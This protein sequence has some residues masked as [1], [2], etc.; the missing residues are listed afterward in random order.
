MRW[1]SPK[2]SKSKATGRPH[3]RPKTAIGR[4]LKMLQRGPS[5]QTFFAAEK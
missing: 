5:K 1:L 4:R 2:L 3:G